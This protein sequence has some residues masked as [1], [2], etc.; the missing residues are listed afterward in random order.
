M[1]A[2]SHKIS[3]LLKIISF[4]T[5]KSKR[6]TTPTPFNNPHL[7][8]RGIITKQPHSYDYNLP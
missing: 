7:T 2:V 3:N 6:T 5:A 8:T 1:L 4:N